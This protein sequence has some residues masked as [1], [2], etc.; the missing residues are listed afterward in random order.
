MRTWPLSPPFAAE[1]GAGAYLIEGGA[2]GAFLAMAGI[3]VLAFVGFG[4]MGLVSL[5]AILFLVNLLIA[6][7]ILLEV[8][9]MEQGVA[10][11][12]FANLAW[13]VIAESV[14]AAVIAL[15]GA[16]LLIAIA[17]GMV[18][19]SLGNALISRAPLVEMRTA[20]A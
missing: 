10:R 9:S 1:T 2:R 15:V 11:A 6:E 4:M 19:F 3:I 17:I 7:F 12:F 14:G 13:A 8:Q 20:Y 5:F 16:E 18:V